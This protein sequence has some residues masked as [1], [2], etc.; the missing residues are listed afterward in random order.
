MIIV[1][2]NTG[3]K[4]IGADD[5]AI[6]IVSDALSYDDDGAGRKSGLNAGAWNSRKTFLRFPDLI[7]E[8]GFVPFVKASLNEAGYPITIDDRRTSLDALGPRIDL[9][10][11]TGTEICDDGE[12]PIY[13]GYL[14][15]IDLRD[16]QAQ[17][18]ETFAVERRGIIQA[19]TGSGKTEIGIG[20]IKRIKR[21]CLW[22]TH[23]IDLVSQTRKRIKKRLGIVAGSISEGEWM[24]SEITV[25]TV[26]TIMSH[27][28]QSREKVHSFLRTVEVL[29]VDE[30]H[31]ASG[32]GFFSVI[33]N[34][35]NAYYRASLTATPLMKGNR[36]DDLRLIA[37]SG[38]IICRVTNSQLIRRGIL[39]E[40]RFIFTISPSFGWSEARVRR[41]LKEEARAKG[42]KSPGPGALYQAAYDLGI[43][44]NDARNNLVVAD[45]LELVSHGRK[46]VVLFQRKDHGRILFA[47]L[48]AKL[49]DRVRLLFGEDDLDERERTL[50]A[51]RTGEIDVIVAST[52]LDEGLDEPSIAGIVLAGGGKGK[53]SLFQRVG[54]SVRKK[55]GDDLERFGNTAEIR[56][57]LDT[58]EKHLYTHSALRWKTVKDEDGWVIDGIREYH[59]PFG[60][61]RAV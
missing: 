4:L 36:E 13:G 50:G 25:A 58:G 2:T 38:G 10:Q 52:I 39:A 17:T 6:S 5:R 11:P 34:C 44:R 51:L 37:G 41:E 8:A 9:E 19:A 14:D 3:A 1:Q 20:I 59:N 22:L 16:Y 42:R 55:N 26:Q 12:Y 23:K 54:R 57:Y 30:A 21:P 31:R 18:I 29:I 56:D 61:V 48:S 60:E 28:R 32:E 49:Q 27:A 33:T 35:I 46:T 45:A 24:P 7:F 53:I 47:K 40:P 43:V 15:G